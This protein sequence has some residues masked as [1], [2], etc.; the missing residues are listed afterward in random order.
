MNLDTAMLRA[1]VTLAQ[2][3]HF[4][5]T[6]ERLNI[7]PAKL[8]RLIQQLERET[9][10]ALFSR[11]THAT[12]LTE[13]GRRLLPS[14][15]RIVAEYDWIARQALAVRSGSAGRFVIGGMAG[16]L[17]EDL[18][19]RIR[20]ARKRFPDIVYQLVEVDEASL[21]QRVADDSV[22]VGFTYFPPSDDLLRARVVSSRV[23]YVAFNL[24]HPLA[25]RTKVHIDEL[26]GETLILPDLRLSPR[27][28]QW[29]R[30]FL[31][32]GNT[33]TLNYIEVTQIQAGLGLCAAG[34]GVCVLPE[35]L[36][37]LRADDV[38]YARLISAP[39][40]ELSAVWR[41]DS[42]TR[43]VAQFLAAWR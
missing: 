16:V 15:N 21:A 37:R 17:Y 1:F 32:R 11:T 4:G 8:T 24:E 31:D 6:S 29:Y 41:S 13:N 43:H 2:L 42:P 22:Q 23:Q 12:T 26:A 5:R 9:G 38:C 33:R 27:L 18:P 40:S 3:L 36:R 25:G 20:A 19:G 14:A 30:S 34:E 28:H 7:A 35:H 39:R 10:A